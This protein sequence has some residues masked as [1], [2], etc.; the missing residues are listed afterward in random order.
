MENEKNVPMEKPKLSLDPI[1]SLFNDTWILYQERF[2]QLIRIV[3]LPTLVTILGYTIS[4]LHLPLT[5]VLGGI[6]LFVGWLMSVFNILPIIFSI[7]NKTDV[8]DSY[9]AALPWVLPFAWLLILEALAVTGGFVMLI[10]PGIWLVFAFSFVSYV[11]V[12][13][14][15]RWLD[16]L[17]Q[18]KDYVRGYWWAVTGRILLMGIFVIMA[19]IIVQWFTGPT[20]GTAASTIAAMILSLFTTPFT[21][22]FSYNLYN[23]LKALKPELAEAEPAASGG[24][25]IAASVIVAAVALVAIALVAMFFTWHGVAHSL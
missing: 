18:S 15:R 16:A 7:H 10:V 13:E 9:K 25:F 11:F 20:F 8:D 12:L 17:R 24:G 5:A 21:A 23:N 3:L 22:L 1:K 19:G 14:R 2:A 4:D 6:V